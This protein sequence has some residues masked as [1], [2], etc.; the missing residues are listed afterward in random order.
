[1]STELTTVTEPSAI[2]G[3][4]LANI[5]NP[6]TMGRIAKL[7]ATSK[8]V[9]QL[10]KEDAGAC[11]LALNM[12]QN[13]K[14]D[15]FYL[16]QNMYDVHGRI[17]V[18][19]QLCVA[20]L[21]ANPEYKTFAFE[22]LNGQDHTAG[23]RVRVTTTNGET[24]YGTAITPE[25]VHAEGWDKNAKWRTMAEQMYKYRAAAFFVRTNCPHLLFGMQTTDELR[26]IALQDRRPYERQK[27]EPRNITPK[28]QHDPA[29]AADAAPAEP[30]LFPGMQP[31]PAQPLTAE[32]RA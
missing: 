23:I 12:A 21:K 31:D 20:L 17:G 1:M 11:M 2:R 5:D 16:M 24:I 19:G 28:Q 8:I 13:V 3:G 29:P 18:S 7:F 14:C 22:Y 10:F 25:M 6:E 32:E 4:A 27:A 26:D 9:P 30:D 15:P